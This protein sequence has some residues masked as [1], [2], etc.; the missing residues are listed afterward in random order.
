MR[1][2]TGDATDP[3]LLDLFGPQ[4]VAMVCNVLGPMEDALA[5]KCLRNIVRLVVPDGHLVVDGMDLDLKTR[6]VQSLS[7]IYQVPNT[8]ESVPTFAA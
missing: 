8:L 6:V 4:D 5:E 7:S 3:E 2:E 1:W